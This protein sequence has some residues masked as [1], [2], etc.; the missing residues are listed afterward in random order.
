MI[1]IKIVNS[2]E[3]SLIEN[4]LQ[5]Y[6]H[7][8][9]EYFPIDF[10]SKTCTYEYD[11]ISKY[12]NESNNYAILFM[13]DD[14]VIGFSLID[15]IDNTYTVQEMFILNN[16]KN[17]GFG[18]ECITKVFDDFN[19]NW[20][21]KSLPLSPKSENFWNKTISKYTDGD[22]EIEHIGKYNRAVF[23]FNNAQ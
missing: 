18:E 12:F 11:D 7:N 9:S 19:G 4:L 2:N 14:E 1:K 23:R 6:L 8:I 22:F 3:R 21:I 20:I 10:N 13:N 15:L 5:M 17:K 16:Y